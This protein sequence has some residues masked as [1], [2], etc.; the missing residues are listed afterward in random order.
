MFLLPNFTHTKYVLDA[1]AKCILCL[2]NDRSVTLV[3][4]FMFATGVPHML[5]PS[6]DP[7]PQL[8]FITCSKFPM[9]NIC[10]NT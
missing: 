2:E 5:P 3:E 6:L 4:V 10:V 1:N 9:A 8:Q 7:Q